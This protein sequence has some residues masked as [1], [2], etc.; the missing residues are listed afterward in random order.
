MR[1]LAPCHVAGTIT[2][3]ITLAVWWVGEGGPM[4]DEAGLER[5]ESAGTMTPVLRSLLATKGT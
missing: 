3:K 5:I 1:P 4:V 2:A